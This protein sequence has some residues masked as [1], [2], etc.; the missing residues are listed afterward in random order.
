MALPDI[1]ARKLSE[2]TPRLDPGTTF[3]EHLENGKPV[4]R[5]YV[6]ST[7]GMYTLEKDQWELAKLFDGERSLA[8]I[9]KIH[10]QQNGVEY[11]ADTVREFA[12]NLDSGDFWY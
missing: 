12:A 4:V 9:A 8:E 2:N 3:R 11:D 7:A 1:P 5:I 10:S 6:P